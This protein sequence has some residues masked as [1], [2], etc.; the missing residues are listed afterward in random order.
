MKQIS[1]VAACED[2]HWLERKTIEFSGVMKMF[3]YSKECGLISIFCQILLN[4]T[5]EDLYIEM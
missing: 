5:T 3:I 2:R 4:F 1:R